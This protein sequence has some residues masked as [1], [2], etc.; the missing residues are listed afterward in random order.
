M[1][2]SRLVNLEAESHCYYH[3]T[4]ESKETHG[5]HGI[6]EQS[7]V[8]GS[9]VPDPILSRSATSYVPHAGDHADRNDRFFFSDLGARSGIGWPPAML[10]Q[11]QCGFL[12]VDSHAGALTFS[13]LQI[14]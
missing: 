4:V 7:S 1:P 12:Y 5:G 11:L 14:F 9:L 10:S 2:G 6:L 3:S 13:C 8:A